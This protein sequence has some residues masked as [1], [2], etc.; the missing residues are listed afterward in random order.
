MFLD[1]IIGIFSPATKLRRIQ[2]RNAINIVQKRKYEGAGKTRRTQNWRTNSSS[3]NAEI[4]NQLPILR[5]RSRDLVR[6]D[7]YAARAISLVATN[8]IGKGIIPH[9]QSKNETTQLQLQELW[10]RWAN[11][12][13]CDFDGQKSYSSI[14]NLCTRSTAESG[15]VLIRRR[16]VNLDGDNILPLKLQVLESD[17]LATSIHTNS[18]NNNQIIQGI[19][20]DNTGKRVAYHLYED[21]PGNS[22]M[23]SFLSTNRFNIVRIP[24]EDISHVYRE[25]R[26]GQ[27]R[28]VPWLAPVMIR[29][30]NFGDF[31]DAQLMRQ[32]IAACFS[33]F[34]VDA[35]QSGELSTEEQEDLSSIEPG[36][37]EY[38]GSGK[39]VRFANPPGVENYKE[40]ISSQLHAIAVGVGVSYEALA[41]DLSEVNFSSARMGWLEFQRNIDS[42]RNNI[43]NPLMNDKIFDWFLEAATLI[44]IDVSE[45]KVSWTA[46]RREMIDPTKEIPAKIK[47]VR[48]GIQTLSEVIRESGGHIEDTLDEIERVNKMLDD[49]EIIL[50]T[51][52]RKIT[53][54]GRLQEENEEEKTTSDGGKDEK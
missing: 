37:I 18:E 41:G 45:V 49:K 47:S 8:T 33:V 12:L 38:L 2:F 39:D 48:A 53:D 54:D 13:S 25:D 31:E 52:P 30:K 44:G 27:I 9:I 28:G 40:Y 10:K 7:P 16:R 5:D 4:R 34:I 26:P 36:S 11:S 20:Y 29:L 21:H 43:I 42:W 19:E 46:P 17:F 14:Q 50:D 3:A 35:D 24:A 15:E 32:K 6:N 22:G 1:D 23:Q 51:D